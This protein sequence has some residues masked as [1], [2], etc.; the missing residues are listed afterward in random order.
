MSATYTRD[1]Y[2]GLDYAD[3]RFYASTYGRFLTPDPTRG[4][5][6]G[7]NEPQTPSSWNRYA[8]VLG[9]P[10]NHY[11]PTG[12]ELPICDPFEI[13]GCC[14]PEFDPD[15]G[16]GDGGWYG[17]APIY[18]Q[19]P[20]GGGGGGAAPPPL[21]CNFDGFSGSSAPVNM[22][23]IDQAPYGQS[24]YGLPTSLTYS[25]SGGN[26]DYFW[27]TLQVGTL[28]LTTSY[29]GVT[30]V[31]TE[32]LT[33]YL[34]GISNNPR[35][36]VYTGYDAPGVGI[37]ARTKGAITIT[38]VFSFTD[39][40]WV[41]SDGQSAPCPLETWSGTVTVTRTKGGVVTVTGSSVYTGPPPL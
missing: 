27:S 38:G 4:R 11:D 7:V 35:G 10:V 13:G 37:G 2:T 30:R 26:G 12:R 25:A 34:A 21:T 9:D 39:S 1:S 18:Y 8:Y 29:R 5:A 16:G 22:S 3:Q 19:P 40:V 32:S 20:G 33:E 17:G 28:T 15:C 6:R 31:M 36:P 24:Y 41:Y 23:D 14:D